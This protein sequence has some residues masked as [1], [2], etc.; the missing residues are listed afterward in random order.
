ME[1]S[2]HNTQTWSHWSPSWSPWSLDVLDF[3][4]L[5]K[6]FFKAQQHTQILTQSI[7]KIRMVLLDRLFCDKIF[8]KI[9]LGI[10]IFLKLILQYIMYLSKYSVEKRNSPPLRNGHN[11]SSI[12]IFLM[13]SLQLS[14]INSFS[15]F[16]VIFFFN[17]N[18]F[19]S[20]GQKV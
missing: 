18:T 3:Y 1:S 15:S 13:I 8:V 4:F 10:Q 7:L 6:L 9:T 20:G 11:F 14:S 12:A 2:P 5:F 17:G 16:S 19:R